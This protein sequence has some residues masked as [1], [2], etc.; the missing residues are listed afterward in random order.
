MSWKRK[1]LHLT[2]LLML[3]IVSVSIDLFHDEKDTG[4]TSSCPACTFHLSSIADSI[5]V[6]ISLPRPALIGMVELTNPPEHEFSPDSLHAARSPP[7][8]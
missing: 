8:A 2:F 1:L 3:L 6:F 7:S 5:V 4:R